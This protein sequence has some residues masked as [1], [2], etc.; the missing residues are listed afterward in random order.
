MKESSKKFEVIFED[1]ECISI[2]KYDHAKTKNGPVET[3]IKWKKGKEPK[4]E[5][6]KTLGELAKE[7]KK[8][9][10]EKS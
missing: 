5:K 7:N 9:K 8:V 4:P 2:W 6:K 1:E 10:K 3:E